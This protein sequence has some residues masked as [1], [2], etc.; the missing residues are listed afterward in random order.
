MTDKP[1]NVTFLNTK[2]PET[3]NPDTESLTYFLDGVEEYNSYQDAER[4]GKAVM[5]G[6]I[7]VCQEKFGISDEEGFFRDSAV[8]AVLVYGMFLRQRG[9][10]TPETHLLDDIRA[11]LDNVIKKDNET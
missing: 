4:S 1:D 8:I 6:V 7:K 2:K 9:I 5:H 11:A 10:V 3:I